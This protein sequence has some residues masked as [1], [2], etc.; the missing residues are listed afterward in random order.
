MVTTGAGNPGK[1]VPRL[2]MRRVS[3][4]SRGSRPILAKRLERYGI[5]GVIARGL[6]ERRHIGELT[7]HGPWCPRWWTR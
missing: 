7:H 2:E 1:Y 6:R 4:C 5:D 3:R